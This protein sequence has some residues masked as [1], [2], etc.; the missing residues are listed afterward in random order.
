MEDKIEKTNEDK[1]NYKTISIFQKIRNTKFLLCKVLE[2][3]QD[4]YYKL[5]CTNSVLDTCFCVSDIGPLESSNYPELTEIPSIQ[6]SL[7][8]ATIKQSS[9]SVIVDIMAATT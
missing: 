3:L 7:H 4:E 2:I 9:I 1:E 6:L 5:G 8:T